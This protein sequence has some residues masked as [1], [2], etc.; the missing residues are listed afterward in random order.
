MTLPN[1]DSW[2]NRSNSDVSSDADVSHAYSFGL[3]RHDKGSQS[4]ESTLW[5]LPEHSEEDVV[6]PGPEDPPGSSI[7]SKVH[8]VFRSKYIGEGSIGGVQAARLTIMTDGI[9]GPHK[10]LPLF[11][12]M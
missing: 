10:P 9:S 12:W 3:S 4:P 2:D 5:S 11:R 8:Q 1:H 6:P 7:P